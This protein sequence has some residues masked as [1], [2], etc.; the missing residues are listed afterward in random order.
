MN[1][2]RDTDQQVVQIGDS[3]D[4]LVIYD[5]RSTN[6]IQAALSISQ[7]IFV[8]VVLAGGTLLFSMHVTEL[9]ISPIEQMV[10]KVTRISN[11]P[12]SAAKE[13]EYEAIAMEKIQDEQ[14]PQRFFQ[15]FFKRGENEVLE[16]EILEKTIVKIGALLAIG[17]GEAGSQIIAQNIKSSGGINPILPGRKIMG[18]FG[19]CD[20]RNFTDA[21]EVLQE[22]VMIFVN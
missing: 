16:T 15:K 20:I 7:T 22:D 2:L 10:Q 11:D 1:N 19:F 3:F 12:L 13:E 17:Y 18:I 4:Y 14:K 9:V 5:Q 6:A 21:T 8:C